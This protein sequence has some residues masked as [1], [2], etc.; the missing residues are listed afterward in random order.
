MPP[1]I[2]RPPSLPSNDEPTRRERKRLLGMLSAVLGSLLLPA[3]VRWCVTKCR[4]RLTSLIRRSNGD[5]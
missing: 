4:D 1:P 3:P 2:S 5:E